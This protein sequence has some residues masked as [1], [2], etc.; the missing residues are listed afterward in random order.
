NGG[1]QVSDGAPFEQ[2]QVVRYISKILSFSL[3]AGTRVGYQFR[4]IGFRAIQFAGGETVGP[5][6]RPGRGGRFA[7]D[8][9][10]GFLMIYP[11]LGRDTEQGDDIRILGDIVGI[12]V[13]HLLVRN[14]AG[15][16][17]FLAFNFLTH[18]SSPRKGR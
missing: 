6:Y 13:A 5:Y 10:G 9:G 1:G 14:Y 2:V 8:S 16:V 17:A 12:P 4:T 3:G 18:N 7:S 15:L 11:C